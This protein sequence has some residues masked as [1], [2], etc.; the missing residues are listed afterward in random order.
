[1]TIESRVPAG[2]PTG[3]QFAATHHT[4]ADASVLTPPALTEAEVQCLHES[5]T[6]SRKVI[7]AAE[8][9]HRS[10]TV[11]LVNARLRKAFPGAA[12]A[13]LYNGWDDND[14]QFRLERV[15]G[16]GGEVLYDHEHNETSSEVREINALLDAF[17]DNAVGY[18]DYQSDDFV[19][20]LEKTGNAFT[21]DLTGPIGADVPTLSTIVGIKDMDRADQGELLRDS[22]FELGA[23]VATNGKD[24]LDFRL[25]GG[26]Q[27]YDIRPKT[28]AK[29]DE[30]FGSREKTLDALINTQSWSFLEDSVEMA[31][32]DNITRAVNGAIKEA[33]HD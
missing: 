29:L 26:S 30:K 7:A 11:T 25:G 2:I 24:E 9:T 5:L 4:E 28:V 18:L 21:M 31:T 20:E 3:G 10:V 16:S 17:N 14:S 8:H 15:D 6:R 33:L 1:M 22:A 12:K 27:M 32:T 19:T 23:I 13:Y